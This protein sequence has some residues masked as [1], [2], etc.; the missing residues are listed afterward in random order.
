MSE[1]IAEW[2]QKSFVFLFVTANNKAYFETEKL[3]YNQIENKDSTL[4]TFCFYECE[5]SKQIWCFSV[6]DWIKS[7]YDPKPC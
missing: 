3:N 4:M 2:Q 6:E 5:M 7:Q 1:F